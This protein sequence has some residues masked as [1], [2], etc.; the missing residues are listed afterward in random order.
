[1][2]RLTFLLPFLFAALL[3]ACARPEPVPTAKTY[4]ETELAAVMNGLGD[5]W[6]SFDDPAAADAVSA[7]LQV[8]FNRD[9]CPVVEDIFTFITFEGMALAPQGLTTLAGSTLARGTYTYDP[10]S[11]TCTQTADSDNLVLR[12]PYQTQDGDG[13]AA[14]LTI[15]WGDTLEVASRNGDL[16]E[17]PTDMT[18]SLAA[19][20]EEVASVS[21]GARVVQRAGLRHR[22]RHFGAHPRESERFGRLGE[23]RQRR[24]TASTTTLWLYKVKSPPGP[25]LSADF[26]L[27]VTGTLTRA[28]CFV[29]T[30]AVDTGSLS[31]GAASSMTED[32]HSFRVDTNLSEAVFADFDV[33]FEGFMADAL[34]GV[35]SVRLSGGSVKVDNDLAATFAGVLDDENANGTPGENV[36][37]EFSGGGLEHARGL[38]S[39]LRLRHHARA[40]E[41]A[42]V[43]L[44]HLFFEKRAVGIYADRSF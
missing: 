20:G 13:A 8:P 25:A 10:S 43:A 23:F 30:F 26:S 36:T 38:P 4:T 42:G 27:N 7:A 19:N 2:R 1:M 33:M 14:E 35:A 9:G 34:Q 18:A 28:P 40:A 17:V 3:A 31:V 11:D 32:S 12:Y 41:L 39:G 29:D 6:G 21:A 44:T 15:D 37:I 16:Y 5:D 24:L 22:R